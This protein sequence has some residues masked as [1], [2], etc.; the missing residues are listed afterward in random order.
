MALM[1]TVSVK[2]E[3]G[4]EIVFDVRV[5]EGKSSTTHEVTAK[6]SDIARLSRSGEAST[7]FVER[8]FQ[9]LLEREPKESIL[10]RFDLMVIATYF[11][12]FERTIKK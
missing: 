6:T 1:V 8:C 3:S 12:E 11:P 9:F 4:S 7:A 2:Q 5:Q 10:R